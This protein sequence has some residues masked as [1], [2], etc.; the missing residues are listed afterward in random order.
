[1]LA[2]LLLL[3]GALIA[4][5]GGRLVRIAIAIVGFFGGFLLSHLAVDTIANLC[6]HTNFIENASWQSRL[7]IVALCVS[8]AIALSASSLYIWL[9]ALAVVGFSAGTVASLI[10]YSVANWH[11][12][13]YWQWLFIIINGLVGALLVVIYELALVIASTSLI[14]SCMV[15]VAV[16]QLWVH[17]HFAT[18]IMSVFKTRSVSTAYDEMIRSVDGNTRIVAGAVLIG[19][20]IAVVFQMLVHWPRMANHSKH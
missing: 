20:V 1:M 17:S 13:V 2:I 19:S 16:D 4:L 5:M 9:L 18:S 15:G 6:G 11:W 7:L 12:S 3:L 10:V 8:G 14:G